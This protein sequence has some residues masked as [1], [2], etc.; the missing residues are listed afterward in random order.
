MA[1]DRQS[2]RAV[3]KVVQRLRVRSRRLGM[4]DALDHGPCAARRARRDG[5]CI[6]GAAIERLD[7][8]SVV[9]L[10]DEPLL[11]RRALEHAVD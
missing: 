5:T 1:D 10:R 8:Q 9:C 4:I 7:G 11:E 6:R 3:F 2:G